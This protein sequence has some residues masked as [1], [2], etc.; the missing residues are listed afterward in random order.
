MDRKGTKLQMKKI[1]DF[2]WIFMKPLVVKGLKKENI[3]SFKWD[4]K[5]FKSDLKSFK[6]LL[7]TSNDFK[8]S[9]NNF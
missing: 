9:S 5:S 1:C 3:K 7:N 4:K 8:N 6:Q 2:V